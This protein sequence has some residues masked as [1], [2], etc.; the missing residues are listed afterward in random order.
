MRIK[1]KLRCHGIWLWGAIVVQY[2]FS[3]ISPTITRFSGVTLGEIQKNLMHN[4]A[5]IYFSRREGELI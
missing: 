5:A 3:R 1:S 4:I 2:P